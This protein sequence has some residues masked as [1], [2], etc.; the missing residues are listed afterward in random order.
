VIA[1][2]LTALENSSN[3]VKDVLFIP[4]KNYSLFEKI[5]EM[6]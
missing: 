6:K 3:L 2:I 1:C 4:P 5:N